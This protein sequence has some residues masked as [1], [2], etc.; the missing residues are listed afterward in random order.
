MILARQRSFPEAKS[1]GLRAL[2]VDPVLFTSDESHYSIVK[3]AN[4]MGLGSEAVV[5]VKSDK[6]GRMTAEALEEAVQ[7]AKKQGKKTLDCCLFLFLPLLLLL[8]RRS[9]TDLR[10]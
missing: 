5:K 2:S 6:W 7:E 9:E 8:L 1:K 4:W 3:G 10:E